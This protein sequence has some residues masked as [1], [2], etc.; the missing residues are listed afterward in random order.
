MSLKTFN[1]M[2]AG[3]QIKRGNWG[4]TVALACA[5]AAC[6]DSEAGTSDTTATTSSSS[7]GSSSDPSAGETTAMMTTTTTTE[8]SGSMTDLS[9]TGLMMTT[10]GPETTAGPDPFCGDGVVDDDEECD[11]G[12]ENADDAACTLACEA[13]L[14]GD[15]NVWAGVEECDDGNTDNA[16]NCVDGCLNATCGDG[17]V[18][19]GESCDDGNDVDNDECSNNCALPSCGDGLV[20]MG[21]ECDDGN[22]DETDACT[23]LCA[24]PSCMDGLVSGAESDV[25]CGGDVCE[26]CEVGSD[27]AAPS[28][29]QTLACEEGACVIP[30]SCKAIKDGYP[31]ATSGEYLVDLDGDGG[32]DPMT[33]YCDMETDGGGWTLV[34]RTVWDPAETAAFFTTYADWRALTIG[35]VAPGKGFRLAGNWWVTL[36]VAKDHMLVHHPRKN[37][38]NNPSCD[39]L[40]YIGTNGTYTVN[41]VNATLLNLQQPVNM[42]NNSLL[43][44]TNNGP[45]GGCVNNNQGAPWF[46]SSC[47]TTCPTY[48][49]NYWP[50]RHPM[51][52]YTASVPDFFGNTHAQ[53]C[54]GDP[55]MLSNGYYGLNVMEYYLR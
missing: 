4:V 7:E 35:S 21:E 30:P 55:V 2:I 46:Y 20:Q 6:G 48:A 17:Y 3:M 12:D 28:D 53:N 31:E 19:P 49:G 52:S 1:E 51:E 40:Y 39:P 44:T 15:G 34:Q 29:C 22:A 50:E 10:T 18:G 38:A 16:D 27:C 32:A 25:D 37:I 43:T 36:N 14:C 33:L 47:C 45:S 9:T 8:P 26:A 11:D 23:S 13:A 41:D 24:P 42:V 54:A 5:L